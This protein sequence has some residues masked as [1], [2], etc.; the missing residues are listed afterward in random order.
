MTDTTTIT[1]SELAAEY[2]KLDILREKHHDPLMTDA[3]FALLSHARS[4]ANPVT[5]SKLVVYW[6]SRGWG[7]V[8]LS[9]LKCRFRLER[10]RR[11]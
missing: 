6:E 8:K 11:K 5:W 9:T 1:E 7:V 10:T 2:A 4:G 3:Q